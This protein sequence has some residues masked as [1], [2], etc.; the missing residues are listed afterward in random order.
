M[1]DTSMM[2]LKNMQV[3]I[4]NFLRMADGTLV[5]DVDLRRYGINSGDQVSNVTVQELATIH[6]KMRKLDMTSCN[7]VTDVGL[8]AVARY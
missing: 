3:M 5:Q 1:K 7:A 6:P 8:W 4:N 2:A